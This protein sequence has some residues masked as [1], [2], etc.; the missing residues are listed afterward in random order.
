MPDIYQGC[1][2]WDFSLV[3]P[4]NRRPVD[5]AARRAML[6]DFEAGRVTLDELL[7]T[8][9]DG[10]IKLYLT[11]KLLHVRRE[12]AAVFLDGPYRA[13]TVAGTHASSIVAFARSN[14]VIATPRLVRARVRNGLRVAFDDETIVMERPNAAYRNVLDDRT[15]VASANG[16]LAVRDLFAGAPLAVL[17]PAPV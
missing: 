2:L 14:V 11:W 1:E 5:Y 10:R 13:L 4:D 3:D 15:I 9:H 7:D 12:R 8:W 16:H 6:A 17:V